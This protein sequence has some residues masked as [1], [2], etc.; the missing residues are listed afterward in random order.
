MCCQ[1]ESVSSGKS[2]ILLNTSTDS[3]LVDDDAK[4]ALGLPLHTEV[5]VSKS[6]APPNTRL[7]VQ[8]TS[9]N[10]QIPAGTSILMKVLEG[11][12]TGP[13][14]GSVRVIPGARAGTTAA[15]GAGGAAA[16]V[17][18]TCVTDCMTVCD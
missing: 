13:F 3:I 5:K 8:S 2:L 11:S 12:D 7:F 10:R 9:S 6:T 15:T 1:S 17:R 14:D 16:P 18:A 4:A